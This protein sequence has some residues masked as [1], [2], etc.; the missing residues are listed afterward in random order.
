MS[1]KSMYENNQVNT[2]TH[3]WA[4]TYTHHH[5]ARAR[6]AYKCAHQCA[7][8]KAQNERYTKITKKHLNAENHILLKP[9]TPSDV[10]M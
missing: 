8:N 3:T 5:Y 1:V 2:Y 10:A 6:I 4:H 9:N 7:H